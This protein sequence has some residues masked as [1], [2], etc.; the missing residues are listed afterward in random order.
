MTKPKEPTA[1]VEEPKKSTEDRIARFEAKRQEAGDDPQMSAKLDK[2]IAKL[3]K[4]AATT[5][6]AG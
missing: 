4:K 6:K 5:P 3:Q 2:K 1:E